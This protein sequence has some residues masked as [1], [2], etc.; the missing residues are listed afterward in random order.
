MKVAFNFIDS[1][2]R[3]FGFLYLPTFLV[4]SF[5]TTSANIV[6][7]LEDL[8]AYDGSRHYEDIAIELGNNQTKFKEVRRRLIDTAR[9]TNPMHPYW[10]APRYVKNLETGL[11]AAWERFLAGKE[12][13]VIEVVESAEASK[14]TYDQI[15]KANPSDKASDHDE[16]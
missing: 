13:D 9:Q 11:I 3:N 14:G 6:L 16:M 7:G 8:N 1:Y 4:A 10:D 5:Q 15:L 12:P 2:V